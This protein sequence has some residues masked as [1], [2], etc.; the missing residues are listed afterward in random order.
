MDI[1][2]TSRFLRYFKINK[3]NQHIGAN[4]NI[5]NIFLSFTFDIFNIYI[6]F[7]FELFLWL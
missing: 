6:F 2:Y 7:N 3:D 1:Q 5:T 4:F